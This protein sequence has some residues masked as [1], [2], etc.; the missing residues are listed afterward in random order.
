MVDYGL[1]QEFIVAMSAIEYKK[2]GDNVAPIKIITC[3]FSYGT[4]VYATKL[5]AVKLP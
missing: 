4:D 1:L 2:G 3:Y 5:C